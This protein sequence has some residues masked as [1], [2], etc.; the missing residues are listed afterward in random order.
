MTDKELENVLNYL[1]TKV[2][3]L[4]ATL[5]NNNLIIAGIMAILHERWDIDLD[6]FLENIHTPEAIKIQIE[7]QQ[8]IFKQIEDMK[9]N[10][11]SSG[12]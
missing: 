11:N 8:S 4:D 7:S 3:A 12:N 6:N 9:K 5:M 10:A 2:T 1:M